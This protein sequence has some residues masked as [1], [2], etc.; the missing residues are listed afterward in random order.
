LKLPSPPVE[1]G[2][3]YDVFQNYEI[4]A[5]KRNELIAYL[6]ENGI[7]VAVQWGGKAVHQFEALGLNQISLP[8]TEQLFKKALML[9]IYPELHDDQ[10][11]FVISTIQDF[12]R[13]K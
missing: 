2:E 12:Y 6:K 10:I 13:A 3:H 4:E 11:S 8:S 1:D 9:P 5:K 7:E